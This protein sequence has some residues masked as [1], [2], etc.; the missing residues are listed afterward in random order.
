MAYVKAR[1]F[2][3]ALICFQQALKKS[4]NDSKCIMFVGNCYNELGEYTKA[5]EYFQL[6]INK[7]GI[8]ATLA[9]NISDTYQ[10]LGNNPKAL[11]WLQVRCSLDPMEAKKRKTIALIKKLQ[12]PLSN[13]KGSL[14]A[15][16]YLSGLAES[17]TWQNNL[18]PIKVCI[19]KNPKRPEIYA[20]F[21]RIAK[22]ALDEWCTA[23]G[24][25]MR[26][27]FVDLPSR[28]SLVC[29][30]T[31]DPSEVRSDHE[32]GTNGNTTVHIANINNQIDRTNS[33]ILVAKKSGGKR[34]SPATIMKL[35]MHEIGHAMGLNGHSP[36]NHDVMFWTSNVPTIRPALSERDK[37]TIK[38]LYVEYNK[39]Q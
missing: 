38:R 24:G 14:D 29:T 28:A 25:A 16:D 18:L 9:G 15:P 1:D 37:N 23:I 7:G 8:N 19:L 33:V 34:L 13:P 31:D 11:Y 4:P 26:Y 17:H 27:E 21:R 12:N 22:A 36:N 39:T 32:V 30:Y 6:A 3:N 5:V 20:D 2:K 10:K 35:C